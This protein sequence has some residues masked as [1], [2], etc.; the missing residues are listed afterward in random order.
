MLVIK[1]HTVISSFNRSLR[2]EIGEFKISLSDIVRLCLNKE[3][4]A[5][6][7]VKPRTQEKRRNFKQ[8]EPFGSHA[9]S[10]PEE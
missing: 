8:G 1:A 7:E 10:F 5:K 9:H 4:G 2:Q 6:H 3:N